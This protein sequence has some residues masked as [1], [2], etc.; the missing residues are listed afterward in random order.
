[1]EYPFPDSHVEIVIISNISFP[2]NYCFTVT[3]HED[4]ETKIEEVIKGK[5]S[6]T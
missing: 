2:Q 6:C 5:I 1:M 4:I 3:K